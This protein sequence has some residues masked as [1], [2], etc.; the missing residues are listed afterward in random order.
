MGKKA[1]KK[2]K[3]SVLDYGMEWF[4]YHMT[5]GIYISVAISL[6]LFIF[7]FIGQFYRPETYELFP[8]VALLDKFMWIYYLAY[9][10]VIFLM[11][12]VF[13]AEDKRSFALFQILFL[14]RVVFHAFLIFYLTVVSSGIIGE[15]IFYTYIFYFSVLTVAVNIWNIIYF[16][17]RR[18]IFDYNN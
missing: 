7:V 2:I 1:E 5:V 10:V 14:I 13:M 6:L 15:S 4:D 12:K 11:R 9:T 3:R 16:F 8:K 17:R 18:K